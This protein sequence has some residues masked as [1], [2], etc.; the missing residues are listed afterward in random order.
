MSARQSVNPIASVGL[1]PRAVQLD[2]EKEESKIEQFEQT[3]KKFYRD[4][5]NYVEKIDELIKNENKMITN[6]SN[7]AFSQAIVAPNALSSNINQSIDSNE[8]I[9]LDKLKQWKELSN[10]HNKTSDHLKQTCQSHVIEPMK[11][12]NLLFPMVKAAVKK[13]DNSHKELVKLQEKLDKAQEKERTGPNLVKIA[14]LTNQV[15]MAKHQFQNEN[16]FLMEELPKLYHS[17]VDYIRPC[18]SSLI[19]SQ[20]NFY[21]EYSKFYDNISNKSEQNASNFSNDS[22]E[23]I[24]KANDDIQSCLNDIKSLSIVSGD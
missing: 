20:L 1:I 3:N 15:Q 6:L 24:N 5:K 10:E 14:D 13:R 18:V 12:L 22:N 7:L 23:N 21:N 4:V 9:F 2:F 17:R 16:A 8:R 19:N 11:N